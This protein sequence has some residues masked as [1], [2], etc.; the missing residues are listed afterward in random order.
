M[1]AAAAV[2][3]ALAAERDRDEA[4]SALRSL[5]DALPKCAECGDVATHLHDDEHLCGA[6]G[7]GD[8][9][10]ERLCASEIR[11]ALDVLRRCGR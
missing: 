2:R 9:E 1:A 11:T 10:A 8:N 7:T 3:A 4:L 5:V 6:H